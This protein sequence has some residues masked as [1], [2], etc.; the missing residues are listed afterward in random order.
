MS[1]YRAFHFSILGV[2]RRERC[3]VM[4]VPGFISLGK[5]LFDFFA[6]HARPPAWGAGPLRR[7]FVQSSKTRV[8]VK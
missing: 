5:K 7:K 6:S 8:E 3:D 2:I 1:P 4:A